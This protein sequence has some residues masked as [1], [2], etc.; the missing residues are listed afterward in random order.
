[1]VMNPAPSPSKSRERFKLALIPVLSLVLWLVLR[2]NSEES[3]VAE[4]VTPSTKTAAPA[5]RVSAGTS[6]ARRSRAFS[7]TL[8]QALRHN[9]FATPGALAAAP[10]SFAA[11]DGSTE[12]GDAGPDSAVPNGLAAEAANRLLQ[13]VAG[14]EAS[15]VSRGP[16][17]WVAVVGGTPVSVGDWLDSGLQVIAIGPEG[18]TVSAPD[19]PPK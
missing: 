10:Q 5:G 2:N 15:I 11:N 6:R 8:E 9:P 17:G 3:Q 13:Q 18:V 16:N 1:M 12:V 7:M 14:Q 19:N 4:L